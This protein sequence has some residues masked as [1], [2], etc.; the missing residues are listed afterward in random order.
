MIQEAWDKATKGQKKSYH[1]LEWHGERAK[2][3]AEL[4]IAIEMFIDNPHAEHWQL[5]IRN[6]A[7]VQN[8]IK[9]IKIEV[10]E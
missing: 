2:S 9:N 4:E 8:I 6:M 3:I 10:K 7:R 5:C 1:K